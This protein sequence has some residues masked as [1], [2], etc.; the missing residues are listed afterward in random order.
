M[1]NKTSFRLSLA[2]LL[3]L[4]ADTLADDD[5][6]DFL[7]NVFSDLGPA[8]AEIDFMSSTSAEVGELFNGK[9][10]VRT[11]GRS[12][13]AQFIVFP[14]SFLEPDK[15]VSNDKGTKTEEPLQNNPDPQ[16]QE[17]PEKRKERKE[18]QSYD[19]RDDLD[20]AL[21]KWLKPFKFRAKSRVMEP[22]NGEDSNTN[23]GAQPQ[24][25]DPA[26]PKYWDSLQYPNLQLNIASTKISSKQRSIELHLAA[27]AAVILQASLLVIA[28][29]I[30]YRVE[31]Y[32]QQQPWGLPCY[33]IGS[34]LLSTGMLCCSIAIERSTK[35]FKWIPSNS[36]NNSES[37]K[38]HVNLYWVQRK[39]R[40][41]DQDFGSYIIYA[42]EKEFFS[43]SNRRE[44]V[45]SKKNRD[46]G[47]NRPSRRQNSSRSEA[48]SD[49]TQKQ[50]S[51][52]VTDE[53]LPWYH[54]YK[55]VTALVAGGAGFTVQFIGLRGLPWPCA[56]AHLGALIVMAMIRALI[57]RRLGQGAEYFPAPTW[58]ELD[59]LATRL[60]DSKSNKPRLLKDD[61]K[62]PK[63]VLSW[64][65]ETAK[66]GDHI[67]YPFDFSHPCDQ[68]SDQQN[69]SYV[70]SKAQQIMLVRKRLGDLCEW[71]TR[72]FKPALA[73]VR[74]IERFL[75]EFLQ[76]GLTTIFWD[77]PLRDP[78]DNTEIVR[79]TITKDSNEK[80][81]GWNINAGEV[82]AVLSLWMANLEVNDIAE[83]ENHEDVEWQRSKAGVVLGVDYCRILGRKYSNGFLERDIY[84][85]VGNPTIS[86]IETEKKEE[87]LG[88][89]PSPE[90][91]GSENTTFLPQC[92]TADSASHSPFW[93][94]EQA[95]SSNPQCDYDSPGHRKVKMV[96]GYTEP[97][98]R[99][100]PHMLHVQHSTAALVTIA[101]QHLFTHFIWTVVDCLPK[102]FLNQGSINIHESVIVQPPKSLDLSSRK[103]GTGRKLSH[104][105]LTQLALYAEKEGL[106]LLDDILLC[107]IPVLSI[108][109]RLPNDATL[110]LDL[111]SL[112]DRKSWV[113]AVP[114]YLEILKFMEE[115]ARCDFEDYLVLAVVVRALDLVYLMALDEANMEY[116]KRVKPQSTTDTSA[117]FKISK[118]SEK[119]EDREHSEGSEQPND[120]E[121][122]SIS[123]TSDS[124]MNGIVSNTESKAYTGQPSDDFQ[125][126]LA[127]LS[128]S[129]ARITKKLWIFYVLQ[130]RAEFLSKLEDCQKRIPE[131]V[132]RKSQWMTGFME[133]IRFTN[134]HR[135]FYG[136]NQIDLQHLQGDSSF[137][138]QYNMT[139]SP[140]ESDFEKRD[141]F[142]WT[143][144]HYAAAYQESE[145]TGGSQGSSTLTNPP[146]SCMGALSKERR[147][148]K[149]WLDNF[150]R[151]P[152]H[153]ASLAGNEEFLRMLLA[154]L[155][156]EDKPSVLVSRGLDGMSPVHLAVQGGHEGCIKVFQELPQFLEVE[157][158]EDAWQRNPVHLSIF[159]A[160]YPCCTALI[161]NE[162][163]KFNP[164]TLDS[165]GN[166]HLA[167]L[168]E[169]D[170][171]QKKVGKLLLMKHSTKFQERDSEGQTVWHHAFRF[172]D[173]E[174]DY[175]NE[176]KLLEILKEKH[177]STMNSS[178]NAK[179]TPLHVA[180]SLGNSILV[181]ILLHLHGA[182]PYVNRDKDQ[183]PLMLACSQGRSAIVSDI[184]Y[185]HGQTAKEQDGKGK[186]ALHYAVDSEDCSDHDRDEIIRKLIKTMESLGIK[187]FDVKDNESHTPLHIASKKAIASAVSSLL[188]SGAD[189]SVGGNNGYNAL[190]YAL[191]SWQ[192]SREES[193]IKMPE[194]TEKLLIKS[195][196]CM[197]VHDT[198]GDTPFTLACSTGEPLQFIS[199][200]VEL[201]KKKG[202]KINL[203]QGD[204]TYNRSP[205]AWAC[206][207]DRNEVVEILLTSTTVDVNHQA[208]GYLDYT[209]LHFALEGKNHK[210]VEMLVRNSKRLPDLNI[211]CSDCPNLLEFAYEESDEGC[212]KALLLH[213]EARSSK[214]LT[215]AWKRII[216]QHSH[217]K[218]M[219][220]W[221]DAIL[222]PKNKVPYPFHE[223]AELGRLQRF[224][225]LLQNNKIRHEFDDDHWTPGDVA[226][227][228]GHNDLEAFLCQ[229]EPTRDFRVDP[230]AEP[231]IFISLFEGPELESSKCLSHDQC[232]DRVLDIKLPKN[233]HLDK[234]FCYL[235]T[236][237]A[238]PPNLRYFYFEVKILYPLQMKECVI[239]FCQSDVPEYKLPGWHEGSFAY[240]GDDGRFYVSQD[241]CKPQES[242]ETFDE[243]DIVGCGLN[244]ETGQGYRTKNGVLLGSSREF[245]THNFSLGKFYPCIG[246]KTDGKE[247][248]LQVRIT[249][250]SS[251][252][253]PFHYKGPYNGLLLRT[254]WDD[255]NLSVTS[256]GQ[257][258]DT[259]SEGA[260]E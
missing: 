88:A 182:S 93:S 142:G 131:E 118:G 60:V 238:I 130:G 171:D 217:S 104:N 153:V 256:S 246:A 175:Y 179:E 10:I 8:A 143:A 227:K 170:P 136:T 61:K 34:V 200:V 223:L 176:D 126:L 230:Y 89:K 140:P 28:A 195:P 67:I 241:N 214:L 215:S 234:Q 87:I 203:N 245:Q 90:A 228:Y 121:Q 192:Y 204:N 194:I 41:S 19:Y 57:R 252:E 189:P 70:N 198:F 58:Y 82:E 3:L 38:Q 48:T 150:N 63:E 56:V 255:D 235:R 237:E 185:K 163:F 148:G 129:F 178:N 180:V 152:V 188:K 24:N 208:T 51:A 181:M 147:P 165:L 135:E 123:R 94:S 97:S 209:P 232:P 258:S 196:G 21:L 69:K 233:D 197:D 59:F 173:D 36:S 251:P 184:L 27:I 44:D 81:K 98:N 74:S 149:W 22:E 162:N 247:D 120:S 66:Q 248:E 260:T 80:H 23:P 221:E 253:H 37:S 134:V 187:N 43:T 154:S 1:R 191:E 49:M 111:P 114:K 35:E 193:A 30:P 76:E 177:K 9:G 42:Q 47:E 11:M 99:P 139:N 158:K 141:I 15:Q 14:G 50:N 229:H 145:T 206:N 190:H 132:W 73:L 219:A 117:K 105:K 84:W 116:Q 156:D 115:S 85:W 174:L 65:V 164:N 213:P 167:Y 71:E 239:G 146:P 243:G 17:E 124:E 112:S 53:D 102:D 33:I 222:D 113:K 83:A 31:G 212:I 52:D 224:Q 254:E 201:S 77:I 92:S 39:Q 100:K 250:R 55:A 7:M 160:Q 236:K 137:G 40:V 109:D 64:R 68:S 225:S 240:H 119:S 127:I 46:H 103:P 186:T 218:E 75:D 108:K 220:E 125:K 128:K 202:S 155:L 144:L 226:R 169:K 183:S 18:A 244:F 110:P 259:D 12:D 166:S 216:Q 91:G 13:I 205:L 96:I 16:D 211:A 133:Q 6:T 5:D 26:S 29:V 257:A 157:I 78:N 20:V 168:D 122:S 172:L 72:A 159:Q 25:D 107:L 106:G 101:A 210:I 32:G 95:A 161:D 62:S 138:R 151:S 79:L 199:Q 86:E 249:L 242:D 54:D 2:L 4:V 231:S 207:Y 45:S